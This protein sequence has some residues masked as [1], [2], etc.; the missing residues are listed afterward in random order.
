MDAPKVTKYD[1]STI[2]NPERARE[3]VKIISD[4]E[5]TLRFTRFDYD[6][7]WKVGNTIRDGF[8]DSKFFKEGSGIV[9]TVELFNDH[10]LFRC[11]V[12]NASAVG[13]DNW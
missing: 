11:T 13:P 2:D 5:Q 6:V 10:S 4:Q 8:L 9:I 12:G 7:A 3:L 1:P